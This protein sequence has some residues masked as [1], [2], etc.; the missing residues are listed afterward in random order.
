MRF[1]SLHLAW[2]NFERPL[3]D[4]NERLSRVWGQ[5]GHLNAVVNTPEL[6]E[7]Y[8]TMLPVVTQYFA[9]LGQDERLFRGYKA[10]RDSEFDTLGAA[11][12]QSLENE[13]RDFRLGGAE[14]SRRQEGALSCLEG[15]TRFAVV[16]IQQQRAR[17]HQRFRTLHRR[18]APHIRSSRRREADGEGKRHKKDGKPG[19]KLT[20]HA[21]CYLPVMQ[22]ADLAA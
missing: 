2:D 15:R 12:R 4:A 6:R 5:V 14:L 18:R 1:P 17:R 16:A 10:I 22:Y 3:D 7:A 19:W 8:N 21:P 9:E 20:L 11:Q 13:L